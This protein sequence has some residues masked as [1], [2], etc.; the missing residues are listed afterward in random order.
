MRCRRTTTRISLTG[1]WETGGLWALLKSFCFI[2]ICPN[3]Q[4]QLWVWQEEAAA[5]G[6]QAAEGSK[7]AVL[8]S[9]W[10]SPPSPG[11]CW[12]GMSPGR[13]WLALPGTTASTHLAVGHA[14][15]RASRPTALHRRF[16]PAS[17][18]AGAACPWSLSLGHPNW[19]GVCRWQALSWLCL[20]LPQTP[21][22]LLLTA[23][24]A[25]AG[26]RGGRLF[27]ET[28]FLQVKLFTLSKSIRFLADCHK[29]MHVV[30]FLEQ[31]LQLSF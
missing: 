7:T 8:S 13:L 24:S 22:S 10:Q 30:L 28:T 17:S 3:T 29:S 31:Y 5:Q 14:A 23:S 15:A 1:H 19:L 16:F 6:K 9:L 4:G 20:A 21:L 2:V 12:R 11:C 18:V 26:Q 25:G 27:L